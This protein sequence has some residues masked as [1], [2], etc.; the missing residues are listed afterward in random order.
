MK[1]NLKL[2]LVYFSVILLSSC[3][4]LVEEASWQIASSALEKKADG[5]AYEPRD[6]SGE[7]KSLL[8]IIRPQKFNSSARSPMVTINNIKIAN[9]SNKGFFE[10]ELKP[11]EYT[12]ETEGLF[13]ITSSKIKIVTQKGMSYFLH[14]DMGAGNFTKLVE[15]ERLEAE[16]LLRRT[17]MQYHVNLIDHPGFN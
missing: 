10:I 4:V 14:Y 2:L 12:V 17:V 15:I 3:A 9:L 1:K 6:I 5:T 11:G 13:M 16:R 7:S 8:Y